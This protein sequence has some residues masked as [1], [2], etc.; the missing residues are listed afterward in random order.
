MFENLTVRIKRKMSSKSVLVDTLKVCAGVI[1]SFWATL[2]P[3]V[4][5][6]FW[7]TLIDVTSGVIAGGNEG[8]LSSQKAWTGGRK[9]AMMWLIVGSA[10]LMSKQV[11]AVLG[12]QLGID[13][14]VA[15]GFYFIIQELISIVE[16]AGRAG[17]ELPPWIKAKLRQFAD[18]VAPVP[19]G[20][21]RK[22]IPMESTDPK[23]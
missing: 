15:V 13:F 20:H 14:S 22:I 4:Q 21:V 19:D 3:T 2:N 18:Q 10:I 17:L 5:T 8:N 6:L 23:S 11:D 1:A 12:K 9:K 16:N 7:L